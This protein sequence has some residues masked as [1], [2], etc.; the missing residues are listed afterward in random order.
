MP[1]R[2]QRREPPKAPN[3]ALVLCL[4]ASALAPSIAACPAAEGDLDSSAPIKDDGPSFGKDKGPIPTSDAALDSVASKL[5]QATHKDLGP[6]PDLNKPTDGIAQ[7]SP[8]APADSLAPPHDGPT[9]TDLKA[10]PD[11]APSPDLLLAPDKSGGPCQKDPTPP[12]IKNLGIEIQTWD[13]IPG[14][15]AGAIIFDPNLSKTFE[16]FGALLGGKVNSSINFTIAK[17]QNVTAPIDGVVVAVEYQTNWWEQDYEIRLRSK[18]TS[19]FEVSI[20]HVSNPLVAFGDTVVAGQVIAQTG[21][22]ITGGPQNPVTNPNY[23]IVEIQVNRYTALPCN[24]FTAS[25]M[26]CPLSLMSSQDLTTYSA[27]LTQLMA[28]WEAVKSNPQLFD[29]AAMVLPG[30]LVNEL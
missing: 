17:G 11:S 26:V 21:N 7:D 8:I 23:G 2:D 25:K 4:V 19:A 3:L 14:S 29:E 10:K 30:C 16:P 6:A 15:K 22:W 18:M 1:V 5:D 13:G 24:D 28:D 20:D 9:T 12:A 27:K